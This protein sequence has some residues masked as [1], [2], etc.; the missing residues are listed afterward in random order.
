MCRKCNP[1]VDSKPIIMDD[2]PFHQNNL[3]CQSPMHMSCTTKSASRRVIESSTIGSLDTGLR[4]LVRMRPFRSFWS[5]ALDG[6]LYDVD[7][8]QDLFMANARLSYINKYTETAKTRTWYVTVR[9]QS[10]L[11]NRCQLADRILHE[12]KEKITIQNP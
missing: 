8:H 4:S 3:P 6:R 12:G 1:N 10:P 7:S 5:L 11:L 9:G 2:G